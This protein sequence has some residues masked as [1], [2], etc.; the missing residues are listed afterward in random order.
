MKRYFTLDGKLKITIEAKSDMVATFSTAS[1]S[2]PADIEDILSWPMEEKLAVWNQFVINVMMDYEE[3][4]YYS[5]CFWCIKNIKG[6]KYF[7]L[8]GSPHWPKHYPDCRCC[9]YGK[10]HG[11]CK[12]MSN[13]NDYGKIMI[14]LDRAIERNQFFKNPFTNDFYFDIIERLVD[15]I[16]LIPETEG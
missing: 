12:R 11:I 3:G 9:T 2:T 6:Y 5:S 4:L 10:R 1:Y 7:S 14:D 8:N 13:D 16:N 15:A